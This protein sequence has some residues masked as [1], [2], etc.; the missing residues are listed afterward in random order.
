M[1]K[2]VNV[3]S[4]LFYY[5]VLMA[6]LLNYV[7]KVKIWQ[8]EFIALFFMVFLGSSRFRTVFIGNSKEILILFILIFASLFCAENNQYAFTNLR[9]V[10]VPSIACLS[11]IT[12]MKNN[13]TRFE[14]LLISSAKIINVWWILNIIALLI[15]IS[16]YPIFL[17]QKWIVASSYYKDLCCGLFGQNRTHEL[18][19]F[20]CMIYSCNLKVYELLNEKKKKRDARLLLIYTIVSELLML[21]ISTQNDNTAMFLF[22]PLSILLHGIIKDYN[23]A[24]GVI[25]KYFKYITIAVLA[26]VAIRLSL[27]IPSIRAVFKDYLYRRFYDML[28]YNTVGIAGSNERLAI[29]EYA[30]SLKKSYLFGQ[31]FGVEIFGEHVAHGFK[32]FGLSS[33]GST[34][35]IAGIW[36]YLMQLITYYKAFVSE[37]KQKREPNIIVK[38]LIFAM[39]LCLSVYSPIFISFSSI[40]FLT[41]YF[42]Y[43]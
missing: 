43:I 35:Y 19:L 1:L 12:I 31:G 3:N 29:V 20:S 37:I 34:I 26:L 42:A 18:V 6:M 33:I 7:E 2:K 14:N 8:F 22:L 24:V 25:K 10:I 5:I 21:I 28:N 11:M 27:F 16:G 39:V 17:K 13:R 32:H 41:L 36:Y 15:Q 4:L 30:L 38:V 40:I 9:G 23:K